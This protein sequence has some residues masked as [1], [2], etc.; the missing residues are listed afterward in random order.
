[1]SYIS[2]S[3]PFCVS[4]A[5]ESLYQKYIQ[6]FHFL[7]FSG[8]FMIY[9][10]CL[11]VCLFACLFVALSV[12]LSLC[13]S[14]SLSL[15]LFVSLSL[16]LFVSLSVCLSVSLPLC[17]SV[18]LS[19][20]LSVSLS[21]WERA[22]PLWAW[23]SGSIVLGPYV[24]HFFINIIVCLFGRRK[25]LSEIFSNFPF[26][27]IFWWFHDLFCPFVCFS[28]CPSVHLSLCPCVC[29]SVRCLSV[30]LS[31]CLSVSK[32]FCPSVCLPHCLLVHLYVFPSL[33]LSFC[34]SLCSAVHLSICP[35]V[36]LSIFILHWEKTY[37][38]WYLTNC[39]KVQWSSTVFPK[40]F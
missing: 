24:L 27:D 4:L 28:V 9:S 3:T 38:L 15:C 29:L 26:L 14:V 19:L 6:T 23:M 20:Y 36:P 11:P 7:T 12:S 18:S 30:H 33:C 21:F 31:I 39:S 34:L 25:P 22:H 2:S 37:F 35:S 10:V 32:S 16:C 17:L 8:E 40:L 5:E 13:P 1:M